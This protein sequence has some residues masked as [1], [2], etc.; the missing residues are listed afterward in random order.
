MEPDEAAA[1]A[2]ADPPL[3]ARLLD[4]MGAEA[5]DRRKRAGAAAELVARERPELLAPHADALIGIGS[6]CGDDAIRLSVAQMLARVELSGER[7][8]Q[9]SAVLE[10]YLSGAD[11]AVQAWALSAIVA[12]ANDHS[13][14]R[15]RASAL[16]QER[17]GSDVAPLRERAAMLVDQAASWPSP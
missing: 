15:E 6:E 17:T 13:S 5:E 7:A 1:A 14:L 8:R 4:A 3:V 2:L 12:I 9:A 10:G 16:V 11:G